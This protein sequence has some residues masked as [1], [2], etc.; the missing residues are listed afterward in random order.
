M[1]RFCTD[2]IYH[3]GHRVC[4]VLLFSIRS[5]NPA[6]QPTK[7]YNNAN[8][9]GPLPSIWG[10]P[11]VLSNLQELYVQDNDLTGGKILLFLC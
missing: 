7:T 8:I 6:T 11:S 2:N 10:D 5:H 3:Q 4:K 1:L 9:V